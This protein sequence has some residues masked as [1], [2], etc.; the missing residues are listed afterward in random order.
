MKHKLNCYDP[1]LAEMMCVAGQ[2]FRLDMI[3]DEAQKIH[4]AWRKK[5]ASV[6]KKGKTRSDGS[7]EIPEHLLSEEDKE[8]INTHAKIIKQ[9]DGF[10]LY[11]MHT[12]L[13]NYYRQVTAERY[14]DL[15]PEQQHINDRIA[16]DKLINKN[17]RQCANDSDI[18]QAATDDISKH[19]YLKSLKVM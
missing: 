4:D 10:K 13:V 9:S 17:T 8:L 3:K 12:Y 19:A 14:E 7:L 11:I 18:R 15:K 6:L 16:Y 1:I 2:C 5:F